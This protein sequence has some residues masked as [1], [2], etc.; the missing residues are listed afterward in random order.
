MK[1]AS[2]TI[3]LLGMLL[4]LQGCTGGGE[5]SPEK[6]QDAA[7]FNAQLGAQYLQRGDLDSAR[8]KL[9]KALEQD[10][11]NALAHV[12]YANLQSRVGEVASA[13][14]HFERALQLDPDEAD[15]RNSY[16]IFLCGNEKFDQAQLQF[17][18]A[19]DNPYYRTPEF[20]LDNAGL[21]MLDAERLS[22]AESYLREALRVN[23]QF[24]NAYLHMADLMHRKQR[25]TVADAYF[26]RFNA[27]GDESAESLLL[28][29]QIKRDA[30]DLAGAQAFASQLLNQFPA[31]EEAGEYLSRPI[32]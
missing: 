13:E 6:S 26:Q 22:D 5:L 7:Q 8:E 16:G 24:A 28:G 31:S 29:L 23:P 27:Y 15:Y 12:S 3:L 18:A 25:L 21:C 32:Q 2:K 11:K 30:G 19:A 1:I 9:L 20:A 17:R 4:V 10:E 14:E